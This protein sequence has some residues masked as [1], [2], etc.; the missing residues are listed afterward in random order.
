MFT[1]AYEGQMTLGLSFLDH[2]NLG[3]RDRVSPWPV[4]QQV[5]EADFAESPRDVPI[6]TSPGLGLQAHYHAQVFAVFNV[7]IDVK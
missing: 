3:F 6:S 7:F 1:Y 4:A 2:I 5:G